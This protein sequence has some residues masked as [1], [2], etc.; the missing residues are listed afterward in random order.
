MAGW[1][2]DVV[3]APEGGAVRSDALVGRERE[4][5]AL[6][7]ALVS[8]LNGTGNLVALIG[9]QGMGK[10]R[11]ANELAGLAQAKNAVV[12][13]GRAWEGG[14]APPY[15][16]WVQIVRAMID[17]LGNDFIAELDDRAGLM[18]N[19]VPEL[20]K[21]TG[22]E[23]EDPGPDRF[24]L[25]DSFARTVIAV[26]R[27]RPVLIVLEDLHAADEPSLLLLDFVARSV[28]G[29]S[30]M[31]LA[32][33]SDTES[34]PEASPILAS[35]AA[36]GRRLEL[37]GLDREEVARIYERFAG[38][39]PTEPML[40]A[41]Y[42]ATEGNPF[43]VEEA[44][45]LATSIG[46]L[47]RPDHSLGFRVPEGA[48]DV[49]ERRLSPLP[50][51]V[52]KVLAI[53]SVIGRE[54]DVATLQEVCETGMEPLLDTLGDAGKARIVREV[55][56]LGRY[57][58][59]H[60]LIRETLY[61]SLASGERMRL[62]RLIGEVL[63][64]RHRDNLESHLEVLAHHFFKSAQA[65]DKQKTFDYL[66]KAATHARSLTAYE[67]SARLF[68]R[69]L[70]MAELAGISSNKRA[71]L[72]QDLEKAQEQ[73]SRSSQA[74]AV[75]SRKVAPGSRFLREGDYWTV[76]FEDTTSRL[77][78]SKGMR[79]LAQLLAHPN[80]EI[81]SLELVGAV[82]GRSPAGGRTEI[83]LHSEGLGDAGA[84]LDA[85]AKAQYRRRLEELQESITEAEDFNDIERAARAQ[86]EMDALLEQLG[87]AV[88]LG[89]RDRKAASQAERAR[90]SVTKA[91]KSA[92]TRIGDADPAFGRHLVTTVK[93]GIFCSY[94]PDSRAPMEWDI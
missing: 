78:D 74:I 42:G 54:F 5:E 19:V 36:Q 2:D 25:F 6:D 3:M 69:A 66:V 81:H 23:A 13:W 34:Q 84:I 49:V 48:R 73:V 83:D 12:L 18:A 89:G 50:E 7:S 33:Y 47:H 68:S 64:E 32:T 79:Y 28:R 22:I 55:G 30:L 43:F 53:A 45:R 90:L 20:T 80:R 61:E 87:A 9:D 40:A 86:E 51:D 11:L 29:G 71:K 26:A 85:K 14:G 52:V 39:P 4:L 72:A 70:K 16:T 67:E 57:A 75:S 62:H 65:G 15:W 63:E 17:E 24:G 76:V 91:I 88:G 38:H 58:F 21:L 59:T 93:T 37:G 77:K 44:M 27:K 31:I 46:D 92:V 35:I 82:E 1:M 41:I 56:A 8:A 60:V 94:N 10:T